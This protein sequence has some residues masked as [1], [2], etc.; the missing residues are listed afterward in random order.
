MSPAYSPWAPLQGKKEYYFSKRDLIVINKLNL[1]IFH[2]RKIG[3]SENISV[4]NW[5]IDFHD[6]W[7]VLHEILT[8]YW[9]ISIIWMCSVK[10]KVVLIKLQALGFIK[11]TPTIVFSSEICNIFK[12]TYFE[13]HLR[14]ATSICYYKLSYDV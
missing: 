14:T 11:D 3:C 10:K 9:L 7:S 5:Q 8:S 2:I 1:S 12:N 13:G 6:S 4:K